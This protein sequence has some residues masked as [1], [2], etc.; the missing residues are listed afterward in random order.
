MS[1]A[2]DLTQ[3]KGGFRVTAPQ[4]NS[5]R[6]ARRLLPGVV[7]NG[8]FFDTELLILAQRRGLRIHEVAVDWEEDADSR[9]HIIATALGDLRGIARLVM[10]SPISRFVPARI[11]SNRSSPSSP[12]RGR[13]PS[14]PSGR[15][16]RPRLPPARARR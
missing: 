8:W 7:D 12:G 16:P 6:T 13:P 3:R 9:V 10:Q 4:G 15:G 1:S 5:R 2:Y 14:G 11:R